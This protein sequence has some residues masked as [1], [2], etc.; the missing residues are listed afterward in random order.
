MKVLLINGSPNEFGCTYTALHEIEKVLNAEGIATEM[1]HIG[2]EPLPGCCGCNGCAKSSRCVFDDR[3]NDAL[4]IA[5]G[6]DA[7]ILGSPV[8]FAGIAGDMKSF[9]DRFFWAG[10][11]RLK[12][13]TAVVSCRR[14]GSSAA[15]DGL[16]KYMTI[17]QMPLVSAG[18]WNMV[19]GRTP[20]EVVQDLE[21]MQVMRTL[22]RN[23]AWLL[24][25]IEA[26]KAAGLPLPEGEKKIRTNFIR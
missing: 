22:G 12:P 6:C 23:M 2:N 19:H 4:E 15:L 8:H 9:L 21:G 20:E 10:N 13:G 14:A 7:Y 11:H 3:V 24:K 1:F 18:Y 16:N 26:G 17:S 25:S 5:E